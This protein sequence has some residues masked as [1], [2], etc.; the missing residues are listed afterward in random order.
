MK[1]EHTHSLW[2]ARFKQLLKLEVEAMRD[3]RVFLKKY[4]YILEGSRIQPMLR[5]IMHDEERHVKICKR[6][7]ELLKSAHER[8]KG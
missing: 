6:F 5:R 1:P 7:L 4:S 8:R 3:Y 2:E